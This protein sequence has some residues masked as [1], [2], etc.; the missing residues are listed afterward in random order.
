M[1]CTSIVARVERTLRLLQTRV[2]ARHRALLAGTLRR[3]KQWL[4]RPPRGVC[5]QRFNTRVDGCFDGG[6]TFRPRA[7]SAYGG[8]FSKRPTYIQYPIPVVFC[9]N[10]RRTPS[11]TSRLHVV[12]RVQPLLLVSKFLP[13]RGTTKQD[14]RCG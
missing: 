6:A 8:G 7:I 4:V 10:I 1:W 13:G 2:R 9:V 3:K 12:G 5:R 11:S 14:V